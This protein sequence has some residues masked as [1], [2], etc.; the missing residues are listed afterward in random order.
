MYFSNNITYFYEPLDEDNPSKGKQFM[1]LEQYYTLRES[2]H[3]QKLKE[4]E[5]FLN[6]AKDEFTPEEIEYLRKNWMP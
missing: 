4:K 5:D 6:S 1:S 3:H 2:Q